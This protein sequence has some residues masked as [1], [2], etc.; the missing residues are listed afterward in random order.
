MTTGRNSPPLHAVFSATIEHDKKEERK[1]YHDKF[2]D[3]GYELFT[4][5][6]TIS[7]ERRQVKQSMPFPR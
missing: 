6:L 7:C 1:S 5:F 2:L 4:D 3:S